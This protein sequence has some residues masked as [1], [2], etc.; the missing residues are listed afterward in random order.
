[1]SG[2]TDKATKN[3]SQDGRSEGG[4]SRTQSRIA[5]PTTAIS[6][7]MRQCWTASTKIELQ[8]QEYSYGGEGDRGKGKKKIDIE[9]GEQH[10]I[11]HINKRLF[12]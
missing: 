2:K 9:N 4:K 3:F 7:V 8:Q 6:G 10:Q 5:N 12:Q 1:L 11:M